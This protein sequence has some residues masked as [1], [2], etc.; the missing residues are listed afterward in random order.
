MT[1]PTDP[2]W[3]KSSY[4]NGSGGGCV[5]WAAAHAAAFGEVP[6]RDS[7]DV[8]RPGFTVGVRAWSAFVDHAKGV[9][10]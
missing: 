5:E 3:G 10:P 4:S 8:G 6:V 7:K 9:R 1:K 2:G